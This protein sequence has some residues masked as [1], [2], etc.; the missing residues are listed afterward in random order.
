MLGLFLAG[1]LAC[2]MSSC[3]AFMIATA[4]LFAE[5]IYKP[6]FPGR[7]ERHYLWTARLAS[8][9]VVASGVAFAYW[10]GGVVQGLEIFWKTAPMLG[11]AFWMG[12]F[13]RRMNTAGAWASALA[14]VGTWWL[15]T[16]G[17]FISVVADLPGATSLQFV[18][19]GEEAPKIYLPWQ[20]I[21]YLSAGVL[22]GV[23]ASVLTARPSQFRLERFYALIRTPVTPNEK[24]GPPCTLPRGVKPLRARKLLP[25]DS[26]EI[27]V[28]RPQMIFG[29][30]AGW[31]AVGL[32]VGAFVWIIY[33]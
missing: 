30:L 33:A 14:A 31:I 17:W 23:V 16:Q 19:G 29:F 10:L 25:L 24:P 26:L 3:D 6:L 21:Y 11:I 1:L 13:W 8:L 4:G 9:G 18:V 32:M 22:A 28:P 5:N 20:M 15:T 27:Y 12:L 2:V 7:S